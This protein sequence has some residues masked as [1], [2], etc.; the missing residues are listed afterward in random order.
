VV[1]GDGLLKTVRSHVVDSPTV[2]T[3][4]ATGRP[5]ACNLCHLDRTLAW[6]NDRL[7]DW[8]GTQPAPLAGDQAHV[9]AGVLWLLT[10]D[11]AQRAIA[12][13]ACGRPGAHAA[14]GTDWMAPFLGQ[15]LADPYYA[16]R[17]VAER[18]LRATGT[19]PPPGYDFLA[20]GPLARQAAAAVQDTWATGP[21]AVRAELLIGEQ[22]LDRA[23]FARLLGRRDDRPIMVRE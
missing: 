21:H 11:A 8:Y 18:S 16:V 1:R 13:D 20:A 15:L 5:N 19:Q 14:A 6:T 4:L 9:A 22:G 7:R 3:E 23:A 2:P 17:F 12:G 10:G